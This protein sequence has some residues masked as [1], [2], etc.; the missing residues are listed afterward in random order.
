M[1]RIPFTPRVGFLIS[2]LVLCGPGLST[3]ESPVDY[4]AR[5]VEMFEGYQDLLATPL[6]DNVEDNAGTAWH[7]VVQAINAGYMRF[8][9]DPNVRGLLGGAR[10]HA[11]PEDPITHVIVSRDLL[12]IWMS[13]PSTA[14]AVVTGAVREAAHFF[15]DP[16]AWGSARSDL[17]EELLIK[18]DG[19]TVQAEL[20]RDRLIPGGYLLS[21]YDTYV[22]DSYEQDG[23][24]SFI[25]FVD[26]F[27]LAVAM[28]LYEARL[29]YERDADETELRKTILDLGETLLNER[30]EAVWESHE[31]AEYPPAVAVHSWLEFT[32]EMISRIHNRDRKNDPLTFDRILVLE[33]EYDDLRRRLEVSRTKDMPM[34]L[35]TAKEM[36][37]RFGAP[38][39][40]S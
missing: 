28:T 12:D 23:L 18:V 30:E 39:R 11:T 33:S 36:D 3:Q 17:M 38:H 13:Y 8:T 20:I 19:Y 40:G 14:Y 16:S 1:L 9:V 7:I 21:S 34:M 22:L 26:R 37:K 5:L 32:P 29:A 24:A 2:L 4:N 6:D 10:F 31:D 35:E 15:R 27:S 25:L